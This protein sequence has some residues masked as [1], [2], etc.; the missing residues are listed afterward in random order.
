MLAA[1]IPLHEEDRLA[2]LERLE[3]MIG[4]PEIAFDRVT[5]ELARVFNVPVATMSLISR[6]TCFYKSAVGLPPELEP[7]RA[8]PRALSLCGHVVHANEMLI[9]PDISQDDRF[10]DN[11]LLV[12][13]GIR[14]YAGTPLVSEGKPIGTLC[15][16]DIRPR[17]ITPREQRLL[18]MVAD[19]LMSE[20]RLRESSRQVIQRT[21]IIEQDLAHARSVQRFLLPPSSQSGPGFLVTHAYHPLDAIGGDFLDVFIR[22]DGAVVVLVADVSGHGASAALTS[23]MI[24]TVFMRAAATVARPG[25]LL[26]AVNRELAPG[27]G[28]GR[29]ATAVAIVMDGASG[30]THVAA[31]GHP[32]PI[33]VRTAGDTASATPLAIVPQLP[34]LI[35]GNTEY[36][37]DFSMRLQ[38]GDRIIAYTDG[39]IEVTNASGEFLDTSGLRG[40]LCRRA[41]DDESPPERFVRGVVH[42]LRQY[43]S[44]GLH[45]DLAIVCLRHV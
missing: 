23:A 10:K 25:D 38:P 16:V 8:I 7:T 26:T 44:G 43:A 27:A 17:K 35:E 37:S 28:D 14:F 34:L 40:V 12:A 19:G 39:A 21:R 31:A 9:V 1:P 20:V 5:A 11:P 29:F 41:F 22:N 15:I 30:A 4:G 32:P 2:E 45:D 18:K 33:L 13:K 42:D 36:G 24:K 3:L 6:D